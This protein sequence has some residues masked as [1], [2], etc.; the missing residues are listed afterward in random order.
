MEEPFKEIA[1]SPKTKVDRFRYPAR[2]DAYKRYIEWMA[3]PTELRVP[4]TK[5][6]WAA[7]NDFQNDTTLFNWQQRK[8]FW[9]TVESKAKE[10]AREQTPAVLS[11]LLRKIKKTGNAMEARLWLEWVQEWSTIAGK[12]AAGPTINF[13]GDGEWSKFVEAFHAKKLEPKDVT[14]T[15]PE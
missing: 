4:A 9:P 13:F 1:E 11:A 3:L 12:G 14:P 15:E 10:W 5:R 2:Y 6:E 8:D 7:Q